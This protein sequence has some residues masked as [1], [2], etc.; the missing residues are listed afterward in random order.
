MPERTSE[1][2]SRKKLAIAFRAYKEGIYKHDYKTY[3]KIKA[4]WYTD[5][6]K[7]YKVNVSVDTELVEKGNSM[8]EI[9]EKS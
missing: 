3:K 6:Y 2:C 7:N 9:N 4:S 5:T 1:N 8:E